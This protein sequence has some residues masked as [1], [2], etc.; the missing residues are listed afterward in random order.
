MFTRVPRHIKNKTLLYFYWSKIE[1]DYVILFL[2]NYFIRISVFYSSTWL[3]T[4]STTEFNYLSQRLWNKKRRVIKYN[5][6]EKSVS[7][8]QNWSVKNKQ[9]TDIYVIYLNETLMKIPV[10]CSKDIPCLAV[11]GKKRQSQNKTALILSGYQQICVRS[12]ENLNFKA[13]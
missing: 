4:L 5:K 13:A 9:C 3:Y 10:W 12:N 6:H 1:K 11:S 7:C 2:D 8:L